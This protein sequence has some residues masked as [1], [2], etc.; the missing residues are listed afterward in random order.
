METTC[1]LTA[2]SGKK[3]KFRKFDYERKRF[4]HF[5]EQAMGLMESFFIFI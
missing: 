5:Q 2:L 1:E 3:F 4:R